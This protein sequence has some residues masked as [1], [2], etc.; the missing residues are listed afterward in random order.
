[1]AKYLFLL[2]FACAPYNEVNE[3]KLVVLENTA[4][5]VEVS[6]ALGTHSRYSDEYSFVFIVDGDGDTVCEIVVLEFGK[7]L[8]FITVVID[9]PTYEVVWGD[10]WFHASRVPDIRWSARLRG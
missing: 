7:P 3:F 2:L 6:A 1:M 10:V 8:E 4:A 9:G 5:M